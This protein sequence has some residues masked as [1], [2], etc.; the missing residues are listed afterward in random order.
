MQGNK[1]YLTPVKIYSR[2]M[3][4]R[5]LMTL[6]HFYEIIHRLPPLSENGSKYNQNSFSANALLEPY[7]K[8]LSRTLKG[9][10]AS[11]GTFTGAT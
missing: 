7:K 5:I 6:L 1:I 9:Y 2:L 8:V 3:S 4:K 10:S 11:A